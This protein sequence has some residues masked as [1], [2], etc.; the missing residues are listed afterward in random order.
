VKFDDYKKG[1]LYEYKDR[2]TNFIKDG[3]EFRWWFRGAD[4]ARIEALNQIQ[5]A[6]GIPVI[7]RVGLDQVKAFGNA[8]KDFPT[9]A[10]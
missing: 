3:K 1:V 4:G 2:Y 8:L 10:Y 6:K 5:A 7:W 9:I